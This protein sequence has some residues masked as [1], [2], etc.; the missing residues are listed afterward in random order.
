M[1]N[2]IYTIILTTLISAAVGF[3]SAAAKNRFDARSK[4]DMQL[5]STR[6]ELY[7]VLW[8]MT[9]VLPKWPR[10]TDVTYGRLRQLSV[11][12]RDWYFNDG[13]IYLSRQ[14]RSALDEVQSALRQV[15]EG[16]DSAELLMEEGTDYNMV[17]GKCSKLRSE[18]ATDLHSRRRAF[19]T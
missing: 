14:A 7:K 15:T 17:R 13:G 9:S 4:M 1:D 8:K 3:A 16:K 12:F 6:L 2:T 18:L 19:L 11:E 5:R 10:A